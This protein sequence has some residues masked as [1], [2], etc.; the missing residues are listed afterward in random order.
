MVTGG[1]SMIGRP[2]VRKLKMAGAKVY[3]VP[4]SEYNLTYPDSTTE[5]FVEAL[6]DYVIHLAGHNGGLKYNNDWPARILHQTSMMSL[7][8]LNACREF[9]V[10]KTAVILASC[11]YPPGEDLRE[12]TLHLGPPNPTVECHGY[13][14]R[15]S[16]IFAR[17]LRK[18]EGM[19][20][21]SLVL[22]NSYGPY[23]NYDVDKTKVVGGLITKFA[24]AIN[25]GRDEVV[26][27]GT[28]KPLRELAYCDD[29]AE[30]IFRA[31]QEYSDELPLN[32]GSGMEVSIL[33]LAKTIA[34]VMCY[35]GTIVC[36]TSKPD[37]QMRK[38]LNLER[39][40]SILQWRPSTTLVEGLN[41]T[42]DWYWGQV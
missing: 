17:Q 31:F 15:L 32:I 5:A 1:T 23:D 8:V 14:K 28:G 41:K 38:K 33:E 12:E 27:W 18:Q 26:L 9:K 22:T 39:M 2:L 21:I 36:D 19:D 16:E 6:P 30:G 37:G 11:A 10:K 34:K 24:D 40:E 13:A 4:H 20:I 42:L 29:L 25:E 3:T 7:N 35:K